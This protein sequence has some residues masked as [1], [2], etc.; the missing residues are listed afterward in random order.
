MA[1]R[2][3]VNAFEEAGFQ[4][5]GAQNWAQSQKARMKELPN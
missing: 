5:D 2:Q 1:R 3:A 4:G